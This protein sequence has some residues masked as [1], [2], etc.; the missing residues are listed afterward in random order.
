MK[1]LS[2]KE[3]SLKQS[4]FILLM[5]LAFIFSV[6]IRYIW[7]NEVGDIEAFKWNNEL[8]I[9]T[10]DGY[11]WAEGARDILNNTH[12]EYDHSPVNTPMA[13]LTAFLATV[14]PF[15]FETLL[16][17]IPA[18]FG[19]FLVV[20]IM[21]IA[22]EIKQDYLGFVAAILGA[23]A[24]SYYNRT[25]VGY[26]D[27]DMLVIVLPALLVWSIILNIKEQKNSFLLLTP[28]FILLNIWWYPQSYS[29]MLGLSVMVGLYTLVFDRKNIFNYK[30]L[31]LMF[32]SIAYIYWFIK[33]IL[34]VGVVALFYKKDEIFTL[35]NTFILLAISAFLVLVTGGF[36]P[37]LR[38]I[39]VYIFRESYTADTLETLHYFA[40]N[41]TVREAGHIPFETFAN[42]ISG[43][44]TTFVL[45]VIGYILLSIRYRVLWLA[46]PMVGL[47]FLAL[48]GGLRFTV[49]AVPFM[50]L[51]VSYI[52]FL[53]AKGFEN[54]IFKDK[55]LKIVQIGFIS[56]ATIAILYPNIKH[57]IA[58]K[59][60]TVFVKKEVEVLDRLKHIAQRDDYVVAWWD[61]GY[62][63]RY[64]A[65]VNTLIDGGRH[66]GKVNF[67]VSFALTKDQIS[68]ANM[69]RLDVEYT[70][71][72]FKEKFK[73]NLIQELKDYNYTDI[74]SFLKALG[75]KEFKLP[76][77][78]TDVYLYLPNRMLD[79][80]PTVGMFSNLDLTTGKQYRRA[81][82]YQA[83]GFREGKNVIDLGNGIAIL[84]DNGMLQIGNQ[85]VPVN[86]FA[87]T[88]YD[89]FG[90]LH[91]N[92]KTLNPTSR[93]NVIFMKNYNRFLVLDDD[94]YNSLFIQ[95]YVLENYDK[96]LFEPVILTP[97]VKVYKLKK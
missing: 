63:I 25:M 24:W 9:N 59:V 83:K 12:Q 81:F 8:M 3:S 50:A 70:K 62:P 22:R 7:V 28:F 58:Y 34:L 48:S 10:N 37:I 76:K 41:Q 87:V 14:L 66:I 19:S 6:S 53:T 29:L 68:G 15:S 85:R 77:K 93:L 88:A 95:L 44:V 82:F 52:I 43:S 32:I 69:A 84:K 64:Y 21:L 1:F 97:L 16:L 2:L 54:I 71:R 72:A 27:T 47:G 36:A 94:M 57:I 90:K 26:Y 4:R 18:F 75:S 91:K 67:P 49:Y 38:M 92:I 5:L 51:G 61:Y 86:H 23:I 31:A 39:S 33:L 30:L 60:P 45:S 11:Y 56:L 74:N 35:K 89:N 46:L 55:T 13:K 17:W 79:I 73:S 96:E 78:T 40:V 20:P 42:R 80:L 65:D